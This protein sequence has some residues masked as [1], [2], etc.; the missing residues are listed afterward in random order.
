MRTAKPWR[1]DPGD[2]PRFRHGTVSLPVPSD[3]WRVER[4]GRVL[5]AP[6]RATGPLGGFPVR[7]DA[8]CLRAHGIRSVR[9]AWRWLRPSRPGPRSAYGCALTGMLAADADGRGCSLG[10]FLPPL[11]GRSDPRQGSLYTI[12]MYYVKMPKGSSATGSSNPPAKLSADR[13]LRAA[14]TRH[15]E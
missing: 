1:P 11:D 14:S 15:R 7:H 12:K 13:G 4:P 6:R 3:P 8:M 5:T 9:V 2:F 10:D